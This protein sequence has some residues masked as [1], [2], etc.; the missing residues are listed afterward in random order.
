MFT[1]NSFVI[2][3]VYRA[4]TSS[5]EGYP[6]CSVLIALHRSLLCLVSVLPAFDWLFISIYA[7][8]VKIN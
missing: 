7:F 3:K 8:I 4:G 1:S 5:P 2:D 6:Y